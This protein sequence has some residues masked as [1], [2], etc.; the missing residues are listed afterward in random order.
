[1]DKDNNIEDFFNNSMDQFNDSPPAFVWDGINDRL[2]Q[3]PP[4]YKSIRFW[5][6][7]GLVTLLAAIATFYIY[8]TQ[9]EINHLNHAVELL[10]EDNSELDDKNIKIN[11]ELIECG[12]NSQKLVHII[13]AYSFDEI[14]KETPVKKE[15]IEEEITPIIYENNIPPTQYEQTPIQNNITPKLSNSEKNLNEIK[16]VIP[17]QLT[18]DIDSIIQENPELI[19][20]GKTKVPV[21]SYTEDGEEEAIEVEQIKPNIKGRFKDWFE[22]KK[23]KLEFRKRIREKRQNNDNSQNQN[24]N[25]NQNQGENQDEGLN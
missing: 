13:N 25:Q 23:E 4:F 10:L 11:S 7:A 16:D 15:I 19:E 3:K 24:K 14:K 17:T 9:K 2:D 1:M 6:V 22:K 21:F 5:S 12:N 18:E 20:K 8:T